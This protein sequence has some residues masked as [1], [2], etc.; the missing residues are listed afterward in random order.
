MNRRKDGGRLK[1]LVLYTEL[2]P[3]ILSCFR[4]LAIGHDIEVHIVH[5]PVNPEAPFTLSFDDLHPHERRSMDDAALLRLAQELDPD[6]VLCSGWIDKSYLKVCHALR[7]KGAV[8]VLCSD[9]AWR[10]DLRQRVAVLVGEVLFKRMFSHAWVTGERQREYALRLG[11]PETHIHTGFYAADTE[12]FLS[13]G[14]QLLMERTTSWPHRFLCVARYI[15]VKNHQLL[16]DAFAELCNNG[17]AGD[18]ELWCTG[19]G[20]LFGRVSGSTSGRNDRI[21]HL[22]FVQVDRM[23]EVMRQCGVFILPSAYEPWGVV[24]HEHACAGFPL[25]LSTEIRAAER[26]LRDGENGILFPANDKEALKNAMRTLIA[27]SDAQLA[28]M[29][30]RS[31][32]R[33]ADWGPAQWAATAAALIQERHA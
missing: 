28:A 27:K 6:L 23:P 20:E 13:L 22:G 4:A 29:G 26:F 9:T 30:Q 16:C 19:T 32:E 12:L 7:K 17:E 14:R 15:A 18:W 1:V 24:V 10:G 11:F 25:V 5:W 21:R 33:G 2:A 3:Y 8:T 31:L